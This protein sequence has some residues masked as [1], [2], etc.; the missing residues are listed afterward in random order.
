MFLTLEKVLPPFFGVRN[1]ISIYKPV[2]TISPNV[3]EERA[4]LIRRSNLAE[5]RKAAILRRVFTAP[6]DS[7]DG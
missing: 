7:R 2:P 4:L 3:M 6:R 5:G 1:I